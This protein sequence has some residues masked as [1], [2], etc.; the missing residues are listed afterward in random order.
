MRAPDED[1]KLDPDKTLAALKPVFENPKVEKRNHN[2]K[3]DQIVLA[4]AGVELAGVAG[5]SMLAHYLLEPGARGAR[6]GRPDAPR[7]RPQEHRRS[8]S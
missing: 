1:A 6:A 7:T 4:A 8:A 3:F 2:I 5:D